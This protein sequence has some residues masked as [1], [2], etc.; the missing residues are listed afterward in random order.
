MTPAKKKKLV[1]GLL[2]A[3]K[4]MGKEELMF[5]KHAKRKGIQMVMINLFK[6]FNEDDF[7]RQI[8]RCDVI[9]NNT[10]EAFVLE[11]LKTVEEFGKKVIDASS[12]YYYTEDKWMFYIKCK[13]NKIPTPETILLPNNVALARAE[14]KEFGKWPVILKRI[15]G[16]QG[17][18]VERADNL[19]E[20]VAIVKSI[21]SKDIDKMPIIAQE[22]IKSDSYRA[23]MIDG[24][25]IQTAIKHSTRWKATGVYAK[26]CDTFGVSHELR[27]ILNKITKVMRINICG[28]DLLKRGKEWLVLE[29]N[30]EPG[31]DFIDGEQEKMVDRVLDFIKVYHHRHLRKKP[32]TPPTPS[33]N[34]VGI[35]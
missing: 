28:V 17:E 34:I 3:G 24:K 12:L 30:S 13:E 35:A 16:T 1:V 20:A 15:Y 29:V 18:Y 23:T 31:L 26:V 10:A 4:K 22:Y 6:K 25:V 19:K 9:Y 7:E 5:V 32:K 27:K 14:L 11:P 33:N 21:W 2:F 8:K